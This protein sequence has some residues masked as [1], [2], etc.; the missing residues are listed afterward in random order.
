MIYTMQLVRTSEVEIFA[1]SDEEAASIVRQMHLSGDSCVEMGDAEIA[2]IS[3][4][5]EDEDE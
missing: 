5:P 3:V 2:V 1:D 4:R